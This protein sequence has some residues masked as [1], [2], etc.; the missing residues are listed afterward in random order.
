M[1]LNDARDLARSPLA[2]S[3]FNFRAIERN[4]RH[5]L[6]PAYEVLFERLNTHPCGLKFLSILRADMISIVA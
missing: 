3:I 5:A 2:V 1:R 4:L 6:K